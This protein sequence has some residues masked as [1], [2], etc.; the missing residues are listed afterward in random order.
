MGSRASLVRFGRALSVVLVALVAAAGAM[1]A[2]GG[3]ER[4]VGPLKTTVGL[5]PSLSGGVAVGVPPLGRLELPTHAGPL[6]VR[7]TVTGIRPDRARELL[8]SDRLGRTVTRQVTADSQDALAAAAAKAVVVALLA[9]GAACAAV[10][11][12][13]RAVLLGTAA[14]TLVLAASGGVAAATARSEALAEP[15]FDGL[16]VQAPALIG[17]VRDFDAYSA[18]LAEL[19]SNVAGVYGRLATLPASPG[20]DSTRFLWVSDIH[21]NPAAFTVMRR[22]ADQF[23]VSG[24]LDTGDIVD[25]GSAPENRLL[26]R[27]GRFDVPYVYV[28]GNHDSLLTQAAIAAQENAVVLDDG[29]TVEIEGVR[30]AGMGSPLFRTNKETKGEA[31]ENAGKLL[32]AGQR[33][34]ESIEDSDVPVDVALVHDPKA[35]GLLSGAVPLVLTGHV[36]ERRSRV[37]EGTLELAQGSSG[38]AGLRTLDSGSPLPLQMS[39]LHFD[40][41]G[42]LLAVDDI[43][44]GGLGQRSV[45]VERRTPSSYDVEPVP[46]G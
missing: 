2:W 7:A 24:I 42:A 46:A 45:T 38:G 6:R 29:E 18:R 22:L 21:N 32:R 11:R 40:S 23:Q 33:F 15:T 37:E 25:L 34:R 43:T 28:R 44:I 27:I 39:V 12:R 35:A 10:F 20:A 36:H 17:R 4:D 30:F 1:S 3:V 9:S 5:V 8:T 26:S 31:E 19:T 41:G 16:L 14:V 13:R